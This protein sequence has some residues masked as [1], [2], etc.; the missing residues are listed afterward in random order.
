VKILQAAQFYPPIV[1]GEERHVRN[2]SHAL[3]AR[4]EV[5]V[6]TFGTGNAVE[7]REGI[8]VHTVR[9]TTA[10]LPFL[11][12][13]VHRLHAPPV[14]DPAVGR[15]IA[16][17]IRRERPDVIHAHNWIVN[18]V[19]AAQRGVGR[20]PVV[21]TLHD[22]S[23]V[24]ATKRYMYLD[25]QECAGPA[26]GRCLRCARSHYR[27]HVGTATYAGNLAA[28]RMRLR[29]VARILAV[30]TAVAERNR[31]AEA[32]VPHQVVPNLIPDSLPP[33]H[34]QPQPDGLESGRYLLFVGDLSRD[35]GI[36]V[37]VRAY[38]SLPAD[39]PP[40]LLLGRRTRDTPRQLPTG[41]EIREG[42]PHEEVMSAFAHA[43]IVL[44]PSVWPDPCPTVVLE[45]MA[46]GRPVLTTRTGGMIDMVRPDVDGLLLPAGDAAALAAAVRTLLAD[47]DRRAA[48]GAA[49]RT[50]AA[51]F[52]VSEVV[53]QIERIYHDV[54]HV[55]VTRSFAVSAAPSEQR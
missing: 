21:L 26:I 5:R 46:A 27:G 36:D 16:K 25:E 28:R 22:Y 31:L 23:L 35:K 54:A 30:S 1:G 34:R 49:A 41:A 32:N 43:T 11:Y 6:V 44:A 47:P 37:V 4:H 14:P 10:S 8:P 39:R 38:A 12:Q 40:L 42:V 33:P 52:T 53:P 17:I 20:V 9:P 48:M 3:A 29:G 24:C 51:S 18:S 2:L 7:D 15:E 45:A 13:D 50:R 55:P 19:L